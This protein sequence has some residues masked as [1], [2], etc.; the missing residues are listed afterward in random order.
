MCEC[1]SVIVHCSN[2]CQK[3]IIFI[4]HWFL[5]KYSVNDLR[6]KK[7]YF[8]Q[9]NLSYTIFVCQRALWVELILI[10]LEWEKEKREYYFG[11]NVWAL[12]TRACFQCVKIV[13]YY[14]LGISQGIMLLTFPP[15]FTFIVGSNLISLSII[16]S[17]SISPNFFQPCFF[18]LIISRSG[19]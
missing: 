1:L 16:I 9:T 17:H 2:I 13:F 6:V 4:K 10:F 3:N 7:S 8:S 5:K 15:H 12:R 11:G 14:F 19:H 18:P